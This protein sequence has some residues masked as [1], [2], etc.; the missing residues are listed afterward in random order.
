[1]EF[2]VPSHALLIFAH[3]C[4][5]VLFSHVSILLA[6]TH[7]FWALRARW[8]TYWT[9]STSIYFA[10]K[11]GSKLC[12]LIM[13][14]SG[15]IVTWS[16]NLEEQSPSFFSHK[17]N[18]MKNIIVVRWSMACPEVSEDVLKFTD[19]LYGLYTSSLLVLL[20]NNFSAFTVTLQL[21]LLEKVTH[22][23]SDFKLSDQRKSWEQKLCEH[24]IPAP[25]TLSSVL[26]TRFHQDKS[27]TGVWVT[28]LSKIE[29]EGDA[30][31]HKEDRLSCFEKGM[32]KQKKRK[33]NR[34][35]SR[36]D[37]VSVWWGAERRDTIGLLAS[38]KCCIQWGPL[39]QS[40]V[41]DSTCGMST[42]RDPAFFI[43][44]Y[45]RHGNNNSPAALKIYPTYSILILSF[46]IATII[47]QSWSGL[48]GDKREK[49]NEEKEEMTI[50]TPGSKK[51]KE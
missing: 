29:R 45:V 16:E 14:R 35:K 47:R 37:T 41:M 22:T 43:C 3:F 38:Q 9:E 20:S 18:Q 42:M 2:T 6:S 28:V 24:L 17:S 40:I 32:N 12:L 31:E 8:R 39:T 48:P 19:T 21:S 33:A 15:K 50:N 51:K 4:Y 36:L 7:L 11:V 5:S 34:E 26:W 27:R 30:R 49:L 46:Q 10:N 25:S 23:Q 44:L 13:S 1:M